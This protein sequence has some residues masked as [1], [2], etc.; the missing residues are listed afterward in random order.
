[1]GQTARIGSIRDIEA[2]KVDIVCLIYEI[3]VRGNVINVQVFKSSGQHDF[4]EAVV[5]W[6]Q[7]RIY[8]PATR[9]GKAVAVRM[10]GN[11]VPLTGASQNNCPSNLS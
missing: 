10:I 1:L 9:D 8:K 5:H 7:G 6:W 2:K 11:F 3:G 4:D